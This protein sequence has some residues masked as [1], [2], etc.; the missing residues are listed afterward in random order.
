MLWYA[1]NEADWT[2]WLRLGNSLRFALVALI[3]FSLG[4]VCDVKAGEKTER[5][6]A[7]RP[8]YMGFTPQPYDISD[9]AYQQTYKVIRKHGD[10][11]AH[12]LDEGVPWPEAFKGKS[13]H[14]NAERDIGNRL[15]NRSKNQRVY[16]ALSPLATDRASLAGYWGD[17]S[18]VE[19]PGRWK[20][21]EFDDPDVIQAYIN[22]CKIMVER[23][24]PDYLAYAVEV[25]DVARHNPKGYPKFKTLLIKTYKALKKAYPKLPVFLTFVLGDSKTMR[26]QSKETKELL[27]Y[28]DIFSVSTYPYMYDGVGGDAGRVPSD[29]FAKVKSIA[30]GKPFAISETG[31]LAQTFTYISRLVII[32][33]NETEQKKYVQRLLMEA[34]KLDAEFVIWFVSIDYDKL[35]DIMSDAGASPWLKQWRDT[36]LYNGELKP[37]PS[38]SVWDAWLNVPRKSRK[39]R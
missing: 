21:K 11:V 10:I 36:G 20:N 18:H 6:P 2:R 35:W 16:L 5:L 14:S 28:S 33:G 8:F 34:A 1:E 9:K 7:S 30:P 27:P 17:D 4:G 24:K 31:F 39:Q 32:P 13:F 19:R 23:F 38:L 12:H 3:G 29:W 37:R 15:K 22:Y 26:E 25:S